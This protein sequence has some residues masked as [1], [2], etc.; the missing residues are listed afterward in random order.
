MSDE[1]EETG[2]FGIKST[3]GVSTRADGGRE[4]H[5]DAFLEVLSTRRRRYVLYYLRRNELA[6]IDVLARHVTAAIRDVPED[7]IADGGIEKTEAALI[8]SDLPRLREMGVIEYDHRHGTVRYQH[9]SRIGT[10]LLRVC[11]ELEP[12]PT[13]FD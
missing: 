1:G 2:T 11:A 5:L 7:A 8:H 10:I 4:N 6:D 12:V 13:A 3:S 9:P